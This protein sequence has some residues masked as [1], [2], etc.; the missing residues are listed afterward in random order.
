MAESGRVLQQVTA[1][2]HSEVWYL[3]GVRSKHSCRVGG[4][5]NSDS[6]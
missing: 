2:A 6:I 3:N 4:G 5:G 1:V